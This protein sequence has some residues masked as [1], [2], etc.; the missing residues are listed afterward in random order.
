VLAWWRDAAARHCGATWRRAP[1]SRDARRAAPYDR[2]RAVGGIAQAS[3]DG[4][5]TTTSNT[6]DTDATMTK[7]VGVILSGCGYLDGA[8]IH[9]SV[10]TLLA[11]D[12]AGVVTKC[13]APDGELEVVDH[14][15][16]KPT[17]ERRNVLTEAARIARGAIEDVRQARAEDLDALVLPGG[18]GAAKWLSTFAERGAECELEPNVARLLRDMHAAGKPIGAICIA[19]AVV[20]RALGEQHPTLT[21]GNDRGTA[22][23]L[24]AMGCT[25]R[26][27]PVTEF[28]VDQENK[29][30][31]TPAYMLG[32][33]IAHVQQGIEKAVAAVLEMA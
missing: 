9:E 14:R 32:P 30:V 11:L 1:S 33:S 10:C 18:Y 16:G 12:R 15:T 3:A 8:E 31:S 25:H 13:Y 23:A 27:C 6:N 2:N 19:P 5:A 29:I 20:A 28:V 26:D 22:A 21:I 24:Q 4:E 17:G 7:T